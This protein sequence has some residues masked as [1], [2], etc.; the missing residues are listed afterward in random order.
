MGYATGERMTAQLA[1]AALKTAIARR[2]P[3]EAVVVHADGGSQFRS[4]TFRA[5]LAEVGWSV[6]SAAENEPHRVSG[7][8]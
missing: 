8:S 3:V 2:G 7:G 1:V 5:V 6:A 4:R